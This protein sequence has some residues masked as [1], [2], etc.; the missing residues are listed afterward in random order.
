[1]RV[2]FWLLSCFLL[3]S[4][5]ALADSPD[6]DFQSVCQR[7]LPAPSLQVMRADNGYSIDQGLSYRELT[8]MG[9]NFLRHGKEHVLGL[10]R[11]E[12][13]ATVKLRLARL[14]GGRAGQECLSPQVAIILEYKPITIFIGREFA[15][16]S[17]AYRE[18]LAHEMRHLEVYQTYLPIMEAAVRTQL[19]RRFQARIIHGEPRRVEEK[20]TA[21]IRREWLP[22]VEAEISKVN[23]IQ[24]RIDSAEEYNRMEA[25][26]DGEVQ[27]VLGEDA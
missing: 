3:P 11:A 7:R 2:S 13:T 8:G 17:C 12:T 22:L 26:C 4:A 10:T 25:A 27:R 19:S 18:I 24:A 21:E 1:M 23:A 16:G 15:R 6:G 20:L 5:L 9:R 14:E